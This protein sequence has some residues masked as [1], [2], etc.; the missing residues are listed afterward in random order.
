[1]MSGNKSSNSEE[2]VDDGI[3]DDHLN[4]A[5]R[6]NHADIFRHFMAGTL[7]VNNIK[8][9]KDYL[10]VPMNVFL[11][12]ICRFED[13]LELVTS[14]SGINPSSI[15]NGTCECEGDKVLHSWKLIHLVCTNKDYISVL[16]YLLHTYVYS[17]DDECFGNISTLVEIAVACND[18]VTLKLL[19]DC[20]TNVKKLANPLIMAVQSHQNNIV[21]I[22]LK[23][24]GI[25]TNVMLMSR[26]GLLAYCVRNN[27]ECVEKLLKAGANPNGIQSQ[28]VS[29]L[30]CAVHT[31]QANLVKCLIE[32]GADTNAKSERGDPILYIAIYTGNES[33]VEILLENGADPNMES[34]ADDNPLILIAC[35][36]GKVDMVNL[37]L[38]YH[39][40]ASLTNQLGYTALHIAAWNG[41]TACVKRLLEA[42]DVLQDSQTSDYNTPLAL[43]AH[44]GHLEVIKQLLPLG[45][46]INNLD[47]DRDTPLHYAAYNGMTEAVELLISNGADPNIRNACDATPLWNAV[48][49]GKK[50]TVK[51]LLKANAEMEC[52]SVGINQHSHTD[53]V[54]Y[55]YDKP[56]SPLWV[57]TEHNFTDI[58]L[59]LVSAG[60]DLF[61]EEWLF[62]DEFPEQFNNQRLRTML[63]EYAHTPCKLTSLCRNYFRCYFKQSLSIRVDKMD[64][65]LSLKS[66]LT[67]ADLQY[68]EDKTDTSFNNDE[69]EEESEE[70]EL[71]DL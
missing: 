67:L 11:C 49:R 22:L 55:V 2:F 37:L 7:N 21:D 19:I 47:K 33:I 63:L 17:V 23:C 44:G 61:K 69:E 28:H 42:E 10:D 38:K 6:K 25:D 9:W 43:A 50:E 8:K 34:P 39:T 40:K 15:E 71:D 54:V 60:Y 24:K 35:Y 66:Y 14:G 41:H 27:Q 52:K 57:A 13:I 31:E 3:H 45:C 64:L 70:E 62:R 18:E 12:E 46:H 26:H 5:K 68:T 53:G 16:H 20:G 58:V 56:K 48:F 4:E 51:L 29:P 59:L 36:D 32:Y 30:H 65:P 1:M